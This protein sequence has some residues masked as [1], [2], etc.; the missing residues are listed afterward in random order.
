M[1]QPDR[2][3]EDIGRGEAWL[4][5]VSPPSPQ[6]DLERIKMR[7][8]IAL[9]EQWLAEQADPIAAADL[10]DRIRARVADEVSGTVVFRGGFVEAGPTH[11]GRSPAR[12]L[13]WAGCV[14]GLAAALMLCF[15]LLPGGDE[16]AAGLSA[17][18]A[19]VVYSGQDSLSDEFALVD[20]S[21]LE[22]ELSDESSYSW[23]DGEL[24]DLR[25]DIDSFLSSDADETDWL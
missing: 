2:M 19:F 17:Y 18:D 9:D 12:L 23:V 13:R 20:E 10:H 15:R 8:R 21:L 16:P 24:D 3:Q 5:R 1:T 4:A 7:V 22:L 25:D 6:P 14:V 11:R